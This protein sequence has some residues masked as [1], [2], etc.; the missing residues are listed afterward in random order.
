MPCDAGN[1]PSL[2][3]VAEVVGREAGV[4][5]Q[6]FATVSALQALFGVRARVAAF[7]ICWQYY[8]DVIKQ[9]RMA[10]YSKGSA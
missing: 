9:M 7:L 5:R 3:V 2:M 8:Y 1:R 4:M 10:V 6:Y